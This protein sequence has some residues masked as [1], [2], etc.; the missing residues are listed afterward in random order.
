M[1]LMYV[2]ILKGKEGEYG[3]LEA[4][5]LE[6]RLPISP[7][8]EIPSIPYDYVNEKP[9]RTLERHVGEVARK[10][11]SC[12]GCDRA[13]YLDFTTHADQQ[14]LK[15]G[16][17]ALELILGEARREEVR[18]IPVVRMKDNQGALEA[19]ARHSQLAGTGVCLRLTVADF[20][21]EI[22]LGLLIDEILGQLNVSE[23]AVDV[24]LDL[25]E[26]QGD[27]QRSVFATRGLLPSIPSLN[28]WRTLILAASSFPE[29]L[30][31]A[32]ARSITTWPRM[33]WQL[34]QALQR[35][36]ERLPRQNLVY[37]DYGITNPKLI[38]LDPRTMSMSAS[39]RYTGEDEWVIVKGRNVRQYGFDQY[40]GLAE[41]LM[42]HPSYKSPTYSWGD[43]YIADTAARKKGPGN[44]TT[45]R[46][47]GTNH[48]LRLVPIQLSTLAGS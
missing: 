12:W 46:K 34:W 40:F 17:H 16:T 35:R 19:A 32:D 13:F 5:P 1:S 30:R 18:A 38:E 22:D 45:W 25:E 33:E 24:V 8:I 21:E 2:P 29:D 47:V 44:A 14:V 31:D 15:D 11:R 36:P 7:L 48:H 37:A 39:I 27:V 26:I 10:L 6:D 23:S 3:A 9:A 42:E 43:Q 20:D 28:S 41:K 4:L